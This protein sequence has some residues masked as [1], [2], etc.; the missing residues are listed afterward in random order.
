MCLYHARFELNCFSA[1][2]KLLQSSTLPG[3]HCA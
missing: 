1:C 2:P 3:S